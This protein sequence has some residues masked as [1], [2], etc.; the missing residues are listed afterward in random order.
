MHISF[1]QAPLISLRLLNSTTFVSHC[2]S[3]VSRKRAD[4]Y[5]RAHMAPSAQ[6]DTHAASGSKTPAACTRLNSRAHD[7]HHKGSDQYQAYAAPWETRGL[8]WTLDQT[9]MMSLKAFVE[10]CSVRRLR[11]SWVN[12]DLTDSVFEE[13][14]LIKHSF[15][16][17]WQTVLTQSPDSFFFFWLWI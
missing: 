9:W 5:L 15:R 6:N 17:R 12:W 2:I 1:K 7:W 11:A 16:E 3:E 8:L 13:Q 14:G 10:L 4:V